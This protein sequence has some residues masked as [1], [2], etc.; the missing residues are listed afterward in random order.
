MLPAISEFLSGT[1]TESLKRVLQPASL[2]VAALFSFLNLVF[3]MVPLRALDNGIGQFSNAV[4]SLETVWLA[5]VAAA[6][7]VVLAYILSSLNSTIFRLMT[8]ESWGNA[9]IIGWLAKLPHRIRLRHLENVKAG[10]PNNTYLIYRRETQLPRDEKRIAP[11][12]LGNVLTATADNLWMR[13]Q[14][15]LNALWPHMQI[16]IAGKTAL[17]EKIDNEKASLDFLLYLSFA[18]LVFVVENLL[19]DQ[20]PDVTVPLQGWH[21]LILL[22]LAYGIY[23]AAVVKAHSWSQAIR[24]AFAQERETLR[25]QMSM[26]PFPNRATERKHWKLLSEFLQWRLESHRLGQFDQIFDAAKTASTAKATGSPNVSVV[27]QH[28]KVALQEPKTEKF[29]VAN[30]YGI[31]HYASEIR[32]VILVSNPLKEKVGITTWPDA[33]GI[34]VIVD[35]PRVPWIDEPPAGSSDWAPQGIGPKRLLWEFERPLKENEAAKLVYTL[36]I[37]AWTAR[38]NHTDLVIDENESEITKEFVTKDNGWGYRIKLAIKNNGNNLGAGEGI[39]DVFDS[40]ISRLRDF[41]TPKYPKAEP[42]DNPAGYRFKLPALANNGSLTLNCLVRPQP[43]SG[44]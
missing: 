21:Y 9:W 42:L 4:L 33:H 38:S 20:K 25:Q 11:T 28:T 32:Y 40:R 6:A 35:E 16:A 30:G 18:L 3:V 26:Q 43:N 37:P 29:S 12:A 15:D 5:A 17:K 27:F 44:R 19:L 41:Q 31:H 39:I 36:P 24:M 10:D 34:F 7:I 8:G 13:Y 14:I 2:F 23:R 1:V 22:V